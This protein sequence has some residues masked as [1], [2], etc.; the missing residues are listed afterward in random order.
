[1]GGG[2]CRG[3]ERRKEVGRCGPKPLDLRES[4]C[5]PSF[6]E[7]KLPQGGHEGS[8]RSWAGSGRGRRCSPRPPRP[9]RWDPGREGTPHS[10]GGALRG[11]LVTRDLTTQKQAGGSGTR[12]GSP[13]TLQCGCAGQALTATGTTWQGTPDTDPAVGDAGHPA[14][15]QAGGAGTHH[16]EESGT[17]ALC[18][19]ICAPKTLCRGHR[20]KL[21]QEPALLGSGGSERTAIPEG[22]GEAQASCMMSP[23]EGL[24]GGCFPGSAGAVACSGSRGAVTRRGAHGWGSQFK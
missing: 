8:G 19:P 15:E 3:T 16:L 7:G 21:R 12:V 4:P 9:P 11:S 22:G 5:R 18:G 6:P 2:R 14:G 24:G 1:M 10:P 17:K 23:S 13:L 20:R